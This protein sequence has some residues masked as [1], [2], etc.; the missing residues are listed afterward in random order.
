MFNR[1][2]FLSSLIACVVASSASV[3]A[4]ASS[5]RQTLASHFNSCANEA[6]AAKSITA[7]KIKVELPSYSEAAMDH[8]VST[9]SHEY[10]MELINPKT[11]QAL[12]KVSCKVSAEGSVQSVRYLS[13]R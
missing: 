10:V 9:R 1:Q 6:I 8:D 3:T 5:E 11:G 13:K 7:R 12:G 2:S 4:N